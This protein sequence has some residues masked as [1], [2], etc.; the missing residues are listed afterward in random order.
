MSKSLVNFKLQ[1]GRDQRK[2]INTQGAHEER[3]AYLSKPCKVLSSYHISSSPN[4]AKTKS[5]DN[6]AFYFKSMNLIDYF[7]QNLNRT[8]P[9]CIS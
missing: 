9:K 2:S 5:R 8:G 4:F 1:L 3:F 7:P 6:N